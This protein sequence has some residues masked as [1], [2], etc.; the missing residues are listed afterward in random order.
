MVAPRKFSQKHSAPNWHPVFLQMLPTIRRCAR[1]AFRNL[2]PEAREE[3]IADVIANSFVAFVRLV[4][5]DK[6][7]L[8]Y[9]TVLARYGIAQHKCGRRVGT[10]LNVKDVSSDYCRV[11]KSVFVQRL[12]RFDD[13]EGV[14]KE[15]LLEDRTAGPAEIAACRMDFSGWLKTLS[16]RDRKLALT[17]ATG[18]GTGTV[19]KLFRVSAGRV[20]QIRRELM[21]SW[22]K[23]VGEEP[24]PGPEPA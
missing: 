8:A 19:S 16:R 9:P 23:F 10:R 3:A 4:E 22:R 13:D 17:L 18:E 1:H 24:I 5:R 2:P 15:I 14:W 6:I 20:S 11:N 7:E 21:D 12:D